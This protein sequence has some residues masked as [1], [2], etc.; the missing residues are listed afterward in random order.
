MRPGSVAVI[1]AETAAGQQVLGNLLA[2][3]F[4]GPIFAVGGAAQAGSAAQFYPDIASLPVAP[5]LAVVC[6]EP[7]EVPGVFADLGR[8]GTHA[9]VVV[10]MAEGLQALARA[11]GVRALG[12]GSFGIAVPALGLN[13]SRGHLRPRAGRLALVSQS[14][15]LCRAVV[16]WAEP[17]GVGFSHIVGIGGNDD[18]GFSTV[19]DWLSREPGTGAIVL[20]IRRIKDARSFLSAAR[21]AARL[22]PMVAIRAG[23]L[24]GDPSGDSDAAFEAALRRCGV[25][26]VQ[27]L[28][29]LLAAAETLTHAKPARHEA[30]AIVTNA[31][32]PA[33]LAADAALRAHLPLA[34]LSAET[35]QVLQLAVPRAFAPR[36]ARGA[37]NAPGETG[38]IAYVG[39]ADPIKLAEAAALLAGASE[40]GGVLVVHAP[41]GE[42]D[43]AAIQAIAAAS[44]IRVPL[45]VCAM[46]ESTGAANRRRLADAGIPVF[47]SPE[48]AVRGFLQL[49]EDRRNRAAA[50]ELPSSAVLR[51]APDRDLVSQLFSRSRLE[52]RLLLTQECALEVLA[53]YGIPAVASRTAMSGEE[54]EEAAA[55]LGYPVVVKRRRNAI[56]HAQAGAAPALDLRDADHVRAA[57]RLLQWRDS[58]DDFGALP[59]LLVQRQAPRSRE[60]LVRV[61]QDP[62]LGPTIGFGQGGSSAAVLHE[63][64]VDLPPLNLTLAHALIRRARIAATFCVLADMPAANVDAVAETLVRV[65]QLVVDFPEIAALEM[66]PLFVDGEGVL[67]V[68]AWVRLRPAGEAPAALAIP[69]YPAELC[70]VFE[71][72]GE[73]LTIR[74][75][76]PEDAEAHEAFFRRLPPE[77]VRLRFFSTMRELPPEQVARLTQVDYDREIAFVAVREPVGET[78]GVSRLV[79]DRDHENGEFAVVVQP[80]MKGTGLARH[81]MDRLIEWGR[82]KAMTE[83][84]GVVLADNRPMLAFVRRLGF[85]VHAAADDEGVVEVRLAL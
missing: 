51:I 49:V 4:S 19:V 65:S 74:P 31:I 24:M 1:G 76:R 42:A 11:S 29:D 43:A 6:G 20:D 18:I 33:Q 38:D 10:G 62:L 37:V 40:V 75:I 32:G 81:L 71:A 60:L 34:R 57:A 16:D 2:G 15:A 5:E 83:I 30:L 48:Q 35:K 9:A 22:R 67:L 63:V 46:G 72:R 59:G 84:T 58:E 54:A 14:A 45:L 39:L 41:T 8:R 7:A 69:P 25:L 79:R 50:R 55:M 21:A 80:D 47:A 61:G 13:A 23:G 73:V 64:A 70:G 56:S 82:A 44:G 12:P 36:T 17:N 53:A 3:G 85:S 78:V 26:C 68:D 28:E 77:D 66:N 27:R 52:G